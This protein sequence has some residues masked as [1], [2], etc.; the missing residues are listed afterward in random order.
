MTNFEGQSSNWRNNTH[1]RISRELNAAEQR[2]LKL[3]NPRMGFNAKIIS[4]ML[5][6]NRLLISN[7]ADKLCSVEIMS[8]FLPQEFLP[9]RYHVFKDPNDLHSIDLPIEFFLKVNHTSGG[10]IGV[11]TRAD[12][13]NSIPE[14]LS[15]PHWNRYLIHPERFD[16]ELAI[17]QLSAWLNTKYRQEP[18]SIREWCYTPIEPRMYVEKI[19]RDVN[20]IPRQL[21]IFCFHGRAMAFYYSDRKSD[22]K[23]FVRYIFLENESNFARICSKLSKED[24]QIMIRASEAVSQYTDM[25]RVDWLLTNDGVIFSELTNYPS[26]GRMVFDSTSTRTPKEVDNILS[27]YWGSIG[28]Y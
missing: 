27:G 22:M 5:L 20:A 28:P 25:V 26:G 9:T 10:L 4:K 14:D 18:E 2:E 8:E 16:K 3:V 15:I 12:M 24:W 21:N 23:S 11:S 17:R 19:Y 7:F 1:I 6:D 13:G